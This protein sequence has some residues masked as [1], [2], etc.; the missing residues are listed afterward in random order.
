VT[1]LLMLKGYERL[2]VPAKKKFQS[3]LTYIFNGI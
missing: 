3:Y 1:I 2:H